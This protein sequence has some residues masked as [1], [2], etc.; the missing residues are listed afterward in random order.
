MMGHIVIKPDR[1]QDFYVNWSTVVEAPLDWGDRAEMLDVLS[2]EWRR[3]HG[4]HIPMAGI[5]APHPRLLRAD[6]NGSS[7]FLGEF[8]WSEEQV[9]YMQRGW[10]ARKDLPRACELLEAGRADKVL[11]LLT[12]FEEAQDDAAV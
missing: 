1:N 2:D 9:I 7:S 5:S 4:S 10:L 6:V 11:G 12:P 3:E 8:D